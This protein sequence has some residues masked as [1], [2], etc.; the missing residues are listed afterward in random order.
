MNKYKKLISNTFL[1]A[2]GTFSSKVLVFLLMPLYTRILSSEDYGIVDLVVQMSNLMLPLVTAGILNAI[3][4]FGLD[5]SVDKQDVFTTGLVVIG[6]GFLIFLALEPLL[7]RVPYMHGYTAL[8]YVYVLMSTMRSLCS[9]FVRA[10]ERVKLY[11]IDGVMATMTVI[12][13]NILFLVVFR[14]GITGYVL[15]TAASDCCS[16]LF[17]FLYARLWRFIRFRRGMGPIV[18]EMLRYSVP[19]IPTTVF[20]WITNV[21]NRFVVATFI[22]SRANGLYAAAYKIPTVVTLVANIFIDAWQM[23]AVTDAKGEERSE[24]FSKVFGAFQSVVFLCASGLILFAKVIMYFLVA[25]SYFPAWQYVP[26][27]VMATSFSCMVSFLGSVYMVEKRS[28]MALVTTMVGAGLNVLLS[29][30][31]VP[32]YGVNGAAAAMFVSYVVVFILRAVSARRMVQ[33]RLGVGKLAFNTAAIALQSAV[34]I[35]QPPLWLFWEVLLTGGVMSVNL[36]PV[37]QQVKSLLRARTG[38]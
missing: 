14:W 15:A 30:L 27:L 1:F 23:S 11:A 5:S 2:V 9:Q 31:L 32:I 16:A 6:S 38:R 19:L 34:M 12:L 8:I 17:L 26:I 36:R 35:G 3:I 24:F 25:K 18:G 10:Q 13:F 33:M 29:F 28:T 37:L 22:D 21:S 4:R 7:A 20:W